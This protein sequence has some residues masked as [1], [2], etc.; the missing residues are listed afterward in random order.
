MSYNGFDIDPLKRP[1]MAAEILNGGFTGIYAYDIA[2]IPHVPRPADKGDD[3]ALA[4]NVFLGSFQLRQ[5]LSMIKVKSSN[6]IVALQ[7]TKME[8]QSR[9]GVKRV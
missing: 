4:G 8:K 3:D 2:E 5:S 1:R 6:F 9:T 7:R